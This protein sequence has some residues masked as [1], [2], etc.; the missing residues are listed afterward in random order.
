MKKL[1]TPIL[2]I[3]SLHIFSQDSTLLKQHLSKPAEKQWFDLK[4]EYHKNRVYLYWGY[5]REFFTKSDI[6]F[7]GPG[8]D[9]TVYQ[10]A[11][12][13]KPSPFSFKEYFTPSSST[14]S[15]YNVRFGFY[16]KH[17]LHVSFG[18]DHMKY[19]MTQNQTAK[20][21]GAIDSSISPQF[22]GAYFNKDT[23]LTTDFLR[24]QHTNGLN[25][26]TID[27]AYLLPIYHY[28]DWIHIGWNFGTGAL[29]VVTRTNVLVASSVGVNN[30]FHLSGVCIPAYSGPRID[31][32]KYFFIA[33]EVK[34]GYMH[35]PWI[36][37]QNNPVDK[38]DH[39]FSFVEYY[40]VFGLSYKYDKND[41]KIKKKKKSNS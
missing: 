39:N 32:W 11:A 36:R 40:G 3:I 16:I 24:F 17:N 22:A 18:M 37:L 41:F 15:Q 9:F 31:V 14:V 4:D 8:Y 13:D 28:K 6:H 2:F 29:L 5:N 33:F 35:L 26:T 30:K 38:A 12:H 10:A 7:H 25:L 21:S 20:V 19:V 34:G 23:K 27:I 1:L